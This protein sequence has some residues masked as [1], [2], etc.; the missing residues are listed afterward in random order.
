MIFFVSFFSILS[1]SISLIKFD[2]SVES[3][4]ISSVA[5]LAVVS[6]VQTISPTKTV[7]PSSAFKVIIPLSWAGKSNVA[8]SESTSAM[9]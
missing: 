5:F 9:V 6:I 7:S 2:L 8:L 4:L 1:S 3:T